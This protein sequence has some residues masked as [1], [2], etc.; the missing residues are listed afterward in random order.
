MRISMGKLLKSF[1]HAVMLSSAMATL[2]QN[3]AAAP[4]ATP[5]AGLVSWW[6]GEGNAADSVDSSPGVISGGVTFSNGLVGQSFVFNGV[7]GRVVVSNSP[8]LNF[9]SNQDFSI[10]TWIRALPNNN[11]FGVMSIIDKRLSTL[12]QCLGY[13][14]GLNAGRLH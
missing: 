5:P 11:D 8:S 10:E 4:C 2:D 9:G 12:S 7:D 13:E 6:R 14:L 1:C 3:A